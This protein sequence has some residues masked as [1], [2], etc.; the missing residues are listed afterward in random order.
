M[1]RYARPGLG[2]WPRRY[3]VL[4]IVIGLDMHDMVIELR[5]VGRSVRDYV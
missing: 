1:I 5:K 4:Y 3:L 2:R